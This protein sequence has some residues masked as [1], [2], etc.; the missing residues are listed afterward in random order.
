MTACA[1]RFSRAV[2]GSWAPWGALLVAA[3]VLAPVAALVWHA[4]SAD[5]I[6]WRH[7]SAHVLPTALRDT[8]ILLAGVGVVVSALG[9]GSAWLVSAYRFPGHGLLSWA[10]LLPLAVPTYI[11]AY[12]YL[13]ILHPIGAV[14]SAVRSWLGYTSPSEFRLPDVRAAPL[15][16]DRC[17]A[18][19]S[20]P[21]VCEVSR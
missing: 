10:L 19:E 3:T 16:A 17:G 13:D 20:D 1:L 11:M 2:R 9:I 8:L 21:R 14:Q 18:Q 15:R 5:L 12:A 7:L 4:L 6:Q